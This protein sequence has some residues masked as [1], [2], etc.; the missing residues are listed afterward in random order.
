MGAP[1]LVF[2]HRLRE[3]VLFVSLS[4]DDDDGADRGVF[5][6]RCEMCSPL[7]ATLAPGLATAASLVFPH[8]FPSARLSRSPHPPLELRTR[9]IPWV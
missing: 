7:L 9:S 2:D 1:I 4:L 6:W 8:R 3:R 5:E